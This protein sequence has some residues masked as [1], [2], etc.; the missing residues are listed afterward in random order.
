M[1]GEVLPDEA[2]GRKGSEFSPGSE[3]QREVPPMA[4]RPLR[5]QVRSTVFLLPA[6]FSPSS[7]LR[8]AFHRARGVKVAQNVEIGYFVIIDNLYPGLVTIEK[9]ATIS[10]RTTILA[11]DEARAY[12]LGGEEIRSP[13][14]IGRNSF[15]GVHSVILPGVEIGESSIVGAGSVVTKSVPAGMTVAG[16]PARPIRN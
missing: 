14:R 8:V 3:R 16:V 4:A 15:I 10:A 13:V 11:H 5:R 6:W 1:K 7:S 9:G 2:T 12:A